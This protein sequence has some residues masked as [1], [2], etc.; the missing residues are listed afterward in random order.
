ML[1]S[2]SVSLPKS[3]FV[4]ATVSSATG[5][6]AEAGSTYAEIAL[7]Q[8][9]EVTKGLESNVVDDTVSLLIPLPVSHSVFRCGRS[10]LLVVQRSDSLRWR[11]SSA[12]CEGTLHLTC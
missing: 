9:K 7:S 6:Y 4:A 2:I 11:Y 8:E 3:S 1:T 12:S 10:G 5:R